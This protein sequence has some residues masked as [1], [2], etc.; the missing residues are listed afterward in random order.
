MSFRTINS[1]RLH[2]WLTV[3]HTETL[4]HISQSLSFVDSLKSLADLDNSENHQ[5]SA[6]I[7]KLDDSVNAA[8]K[9]LKRCNKLIRIADK[10][11]A[12]WSAVD[13]YISDE[14]KSLL[15]RKTG[16]RPEEDPRC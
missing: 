3:F 1:N 5:V 7:L 10:S 12:G 4:Q 11:E 16:R 2:P 8:S 14:L 13:E 15:V 9:A 6:L